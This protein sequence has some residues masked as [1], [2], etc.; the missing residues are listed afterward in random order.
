MAFVADT[1]LAPPTQESLL[2]DGA[3][4]YAVP[5]GMPDLAG[6]RYLHPGW[7]LGQVKSAR[8]ERDRFEPSHALALGVKSDMARHVVDFSVDNPMLLSYL[9][10][11]T[12]ESAGEDG[13]TLV[14]VDSLPLGWA[15]RVAGRLKSHY[16]KGLR[17]VGG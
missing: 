17:R 7:W 4:L 2:L 9:R 3:Y 11:E 13:W 10:G 8:F 14:A 12:I 16:P 5:A 6:L 15:K 1:F